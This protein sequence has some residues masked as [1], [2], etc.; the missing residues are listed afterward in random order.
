MTVKSAGNSVKTPETVHR[1]SIL[2][3]QRILGNNLPAEDILSKS[4]IVM[5]EN[6]DDDDDLLT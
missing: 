5:I 6:D 3:Q 1:R 4:L 2:A